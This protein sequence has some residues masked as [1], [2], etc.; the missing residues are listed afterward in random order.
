MCSTQEDEKSIG[1]KNFIRKT[2]LTVQVGKY[3]RRRED[4]I[5]MCRKLVDPGVWTRFCLTQGRDQWRVL[6]KSVIS[7]RVT[8]N[9][10]K[11]D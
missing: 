11:L 1:S 8:K 3:K 5:K 6:V 7:L 4:N 2:E 10:A 9:C